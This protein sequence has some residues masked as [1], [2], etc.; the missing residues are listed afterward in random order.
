MTA[1]IG[2]LRRSGQPDAAVV[3]RRLLEAEVAGAD[4][5]RWWG[6]MP[7]SS[8]DPI[9]AR[10][11]SPS[12][13]STFEACALRWFLENHGGGRETSLAQAVG[14]A[15][16]SIAERMFTE[17]LTLADLDRVFAET[18]A[19]LDPPSGWVGEYERQ[20][21]WRMVL[22]LEE[23]QRESGRT[24]VAI[25]VEFDHE[26]AGVKV[27][28]T[29]DRVDR[30]DDG[31]VVLVDFKT[32]SQAIS[33]TDA[34]ADAQLTLYQLA[35]HE[36]A[37]QETLGDVTIAGAELVYVGRD[38]KGATTRSQ[39][40]ADME[41]ARERLITI[42]SGINAATFIASPSKECQHCAVRTSCP[43]VLSGRTG[44]G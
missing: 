21:A 44:T 39:P 32:G 30:T 1:L 38:T 9:G 8:D 41:A 3:L 11:V 22:K 17:Q 15:I 26:I 13:A 43:A 10:A 5:D 14:I 16:H 29:I 20:R 25:E 4:P 24:P 27:K 23:W 12:T 2:E 36:G 33:K 28:G 19:T 31:A 7:M 18:W 35:V 40:P 42:A 6:L 37:V 34:K